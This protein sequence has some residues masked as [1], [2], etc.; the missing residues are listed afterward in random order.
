MYIYTALSPLNQR[1][2]R[3]WN[4]VGDPQM[5]VWCLGFMGSSGIRS[6]S[7]PL[8]KILK[9]HS[10]LFLGGQVSMEQEMQPGEQRQDN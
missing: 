6:L 7:S 1:L 2:G 3:A 8:L 10:C 9:V 4:Y 5:I